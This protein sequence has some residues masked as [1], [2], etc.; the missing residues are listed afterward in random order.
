MYDSVGSKLKT[1]AK[2]F[3]IISTIA[4]I[5][6]G[7]ILLIKFPNNDFTKIISIFIMLLVPLFSW[8]FSWFI[9]GFGELIEDTCSIARHLEQSNSSEPSLF[10][11]FDNSAPIFCDEKH[12]IRSK[13]EHSKQS[14]NT[15]DAKFETAST[16]AL[17]SHNECFCP[18]CGKALTFD[19]AIGIKQCMQC[20]AFLKITKNK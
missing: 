17:D 12:A 19:S 3:F 8:I 15:I 16:V 13:Q 20:K 7:I 10:S 14:L 1:L 4:S 18:K 2:V 5:I 6:V 11:N 9:Y